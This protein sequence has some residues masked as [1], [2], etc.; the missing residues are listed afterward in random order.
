MHN[1][2]KCGCRTYHKSAKIEYIKLQEVFIILSFHHATYLLTDSVK[3]G[4]H[5][6]SSR[7]ELTGVKNAP[8]FSGRQLGP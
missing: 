3:V 8:E 4:F 6:P 2:K 5:Y 7:P 1:D